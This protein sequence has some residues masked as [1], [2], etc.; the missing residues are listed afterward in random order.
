MNR[1][2]DARSDDETWRTDLGWG[3]HGPM[4]R[5]RETAQIPR[6]LSLPL[7]GPSKPLTPRATDMI[8]R[9]QALFTQNIYKGLDRF[10]RKFKHLE[11]VQ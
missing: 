11:P 7:T 5:E 2:C 10:N 4:L 8:I 6:F 3:L 9:S 1:E